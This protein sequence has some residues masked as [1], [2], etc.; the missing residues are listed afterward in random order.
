MQSDSRPL[1][2]SSRLL[3]RLCF[4]FDFKKRKKRKKKRRKKRK[5]KGKKKPGIGRSLGPERTWAQYFSSSF[6]MAIL[7]PKSNASSL[8]GFSPLSAFFDFCFSNLIFFFWSFFFIFLFL[9]I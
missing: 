3:L 6:S 5:R 8:Y 4:V 9:I 1:P 7:F 2:F